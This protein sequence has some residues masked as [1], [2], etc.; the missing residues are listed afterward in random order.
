ML[1]QSPEPLRLGPTRFELIRFDRPCTRP[2]S[3]QAGALAVEFALKLGLP[4][5]EFG[6]EF[7]ILGREFIELLLNN[8]QTI[9]E[10]CS[11]LRDRGIEF[12]LLCCSQAGD[13]FINS[14]GIL[15]DKAGLKTFGPLFPLNCDGIIETGDLGSHSRLG[16]A[17]LGPHY[18]D[19]GSAVLLNH[20]AD[21]VA[22]KKQNQRVG[23]CQAH[24]NGHTQ[25]EG[26]LGE[27]A[28]PGKERAI[29]GQE[30]PVDG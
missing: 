24:E 19:F 7:G 11:R 14:S 26:K 17:E 18:F 22:E 2:F 16:F 23:N 21:R 29:A 10:G 25:S 12:R 30:R 3:D 13:G 15:N 1:Q 28:G 27:L 9:I 6:L 20:R 4:I 8:N 5:R